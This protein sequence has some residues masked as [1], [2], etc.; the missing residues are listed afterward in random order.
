MTSD[1]DFPDP[2]IEAYELATELLSFVTAARISDAFLR[3]RAVEAA[4]R[5]CA[6]IAEAATL[7]TGEERLNLLGIARGAACAIA[8]AFDIGAMMGECSERAATRGQ[9]CAA[10]VVDVLTALIAPGLET[11]EEGNLSRDRLVS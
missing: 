1:V 6:S 11:A 9:R 3:D 2:A 5:A 7:P 8:A 4:K 10:E